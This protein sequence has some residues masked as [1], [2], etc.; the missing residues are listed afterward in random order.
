MGNGAKLVIKDHPTLP[1]ELELRAGK[2]CVGRSPASDILIE[3]PTVSSRHAEITVTDIAVVVEDL[4][5]TNGSFM[6]G[7]R[8]KKGVLQPGHVLKFG[9]VEMLLEMPMASISIPE[10]S[11]PYLPSSIVF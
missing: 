7:Q 11:K 6:D 3:H 2:N 4:E 10:I 1:R 5:S 9:D 8:F